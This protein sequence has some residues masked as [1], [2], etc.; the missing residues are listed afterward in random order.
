M[1]FARFHARPQ[2]VLGRFRPIALLLMLALVLVQGLAVAPAGAAQASPVAAELQMLAAKAQAKGTMRV[3][4]GVRVATALEGTLPDAAA[5]ESQR[6][7]I[8]QA[9]QAL[10]QRLAGKNVRVVAQFEIIPYMT[11]EADATAL[12]ALTADA[13]V[14]SVQEDVAVPPILKESIP[15]IGGSTTGTFGTAQRTG[16]GQTVAILDTGVMK[17][18]AFLSGKVVSEACYSS[19]NASQGSTAV[20]TPNSTASGSGVNCSTSIDGCDHGTHVGGIVAGKAYSGQPGGP[21]N[22]VAKD[23]KLIAIQVFSRFTGTNCGGASECVLSF[24]TDQLKGLERVF[25]LRNDFAIASANMSLG[26]GQLFSSCDSDSRKAIIDQLASVGIATAIASGND[27]FTNSVGAP[28][29]I[30]TA[31]TVGSTTK[32]DTV[33]SFSNSASMVDLLAPGS[34]INS[35]VTS[36]PN[37]FESFNGTSMATPHVAGAWAVVKQQ[38]PTATVNEVLSALQNTGLAITDS[39]SP[40]I[41]KKRIKLSAAVN[42]FPTG[43]NPVPVMT[44]ISPNKMEAGFPSFTLT[45]TGSKFVPGS[46]VRWK[47][48]DRLTTYV[49]ATQLKATISKT[50]IAAAGTA[51]VKVFNP[52]PV[53]GT[54]AAATFTINPPATAPLPKISVINPT[55][56]AAGT[57]AFTLIVKSATNTFVPRSVVVWAGVAKPTTYVSPTELRASIPAADMTTQGTKVI[58]V[59]TSAPGGGTSNAVNFTITAPVSPCQTDEPNNGIAN[60]KTIPLG[61]T[62]TYAICTVGDK[63]FIKITGTTGQKY[64]IVAS[65]VAPSLDVVIEGFDAT[66]VSIGAVDEASAGGQEIAIL[67]F[68][69]NG[70]LYIAFNEWLNNAAGSNFTYNVRV[71]LEPAASG[72]GIS[73]ATGLTAL[74]G[75]SDKNGAK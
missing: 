44:S 45:V 49:S 23:A 39:K 9:Q 69:S 75:T 4:V 47:N 17:T 52:A 48:L 56:R 37:A 72:N 31:V 21:F 10:I 15:L 28:G 64:R 25:A 54:S 46:V 18:H 70:P 53:G 51:Q 20:C 41:T 14:T 66:G 34:A 40:T 33:S 62:R 71:T 13:A 58:T 61:T 55:S 12:T 7:G 8:A 35:S 67:T 30:S 38:K 65:N 59:K 6:R 1:I 16:L 19:T 2:A 42:T 73:G 22:G 29:C 27:G 60:A 36:G 5:V 74:D 57:G 3:I 50:D 68:G 11:L 43:N 26:G 32:Q 63:D 24:T